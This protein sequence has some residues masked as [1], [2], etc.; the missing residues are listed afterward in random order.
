MYLN[1]SNMLLVLFAMVLILPA[2]GGKGSANDLFECFRA[3][4]EGGNIFCELSGHGKFKSLY[5]GT[6]ELQCGGTTMELPEEACPSGSM[7][8][9]CTEKDREN[10]R[11]WGKEMQEKK[12]RL[13]KILCKG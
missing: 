1:I 2:S 7:D 8:E 4:Y 6:C 3:A 12:D 13:A 9:P 11:K 5:Y 10:L